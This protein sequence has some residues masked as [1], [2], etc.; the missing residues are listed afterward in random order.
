MSQIIETL[1]EQVSRSQFHKAVIEFGY[2]RV[3]VERIEIQDCS[4][5]FRITIS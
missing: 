2:D 5:I 1:D 4:P 3:K